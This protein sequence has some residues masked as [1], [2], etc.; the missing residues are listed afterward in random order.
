MKRI[1]I[2]YVLWELFAAVAVVSM[3]CIVHLR[4]A[5]R[6]HQHAHVHKHTL[7]QLMEGLWQ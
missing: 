3:Y 4:I 2:F 1:S 5:M 7:S 6:A